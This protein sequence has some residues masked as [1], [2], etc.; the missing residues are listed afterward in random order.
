[1]EVDVFE[2][3][4]HLS[5]YRIVVNTVISEFIETVFLKGLGINETYVISCA[6][7]SYF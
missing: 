1:M 6:I 3:R 2:P 5:M 7:I 4:M